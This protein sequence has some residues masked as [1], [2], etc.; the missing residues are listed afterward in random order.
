MIVYSTE[1]PIDYGQCGMTVRVHV[2]CAEGLKFEF[3]SMP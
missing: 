1:Y 3:D 2:S